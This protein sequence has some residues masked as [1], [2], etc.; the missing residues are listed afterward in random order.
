M[1]HA[2]E[3]A[4]GNADGWAMLSM[5][6]GEEHKFG[7]NV[8]PDPLGRA[9]QAARRAIDA[10]STNN[11]AWLALA[12]SLFFRKEFEP[13]R[14]AA[15]RAIALNPMD[16]STLEYLGHLIAFAGDWERGCEI[17][18]RARQLNPNHPGWYWVVPYLDAYRKGDYRSARPFILKAVLRGGGAHVF[19]QAL[20]AAVC[21]Q[22]GEQE[23][24]EET[25]RKILSASPE[26]ALSARQEFAKWYLP[27]LVDQLMEGLH[28]A[29]L[30]IRRAE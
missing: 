22:L 5:M 1:E 25:L 13:F 9:L 3:Q 10:A 16:G 11:I 18:E 29:G 7:F 17:D 30:E 20:L 4:P 15:D 26:F 28:K 6:Y 24:A 2:V 14:D 21:G 27:E 8:R 12:Q 19:T 23:A